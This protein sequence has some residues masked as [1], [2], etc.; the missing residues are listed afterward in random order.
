MLTEAELNQ[1][2]YYVKDFLYESVNS[3]DQEWVRTFPRAADHRWQH[4]LNVV[5]NAE[6]ILLGESADEEIVSVVRVAAL[7]HDI[8]MF[9]CDHSIHGQV[10]ADMASEYLL[11]HDFSPDFV[12]RVSTAIAEHGTD[13]GDLSPSEQGEQFSWEGKVLV[14]AD[15]LDK[16][17]VSAITNG[18]MYIGKQGKLNFE[19]R[20]ELLNSATYDR[21]DFFK[22]YFWTETGRQMAN[23]RFL[24]FEEYLDRLKE[25]VIDSD[26]PKWGV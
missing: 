19:A 3:S 2:A 12:S 14:E 21:A 1:I 23:R 4:T 25:E 7:M 5:A 11:T 13:F 8:S 17:G 6:E 18:L 15:I 22:N 9:T 20:D 16:L 24:F 26:M 10:S